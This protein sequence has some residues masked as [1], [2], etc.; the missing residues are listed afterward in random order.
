M[1]HSWTSWHVSHFWTSA[2]NDH[3]DHSCTILENVKVGTLMK[4][5]TF[6]ETWSTLDNSDSL[7]WNWLFIRALMCLLNDLTGSRLP[8]ADS[9]F[10]C[11]EW[12][13]EW[14]W[15][16]QRIGVGLPTR[17]QMI[18]TNTKESNRKTIYKSASSTESGSADL[19][20]FILRILISFSSFFLTELAR[21]LASTSLPQTFLNYSLPFLLLLIQFLTLIPPG[22]LL[23]RGYLMSFL[24]FLESQRIPSP[25]FPVC[26]HI[27]FL[28]EMWRIAD[29]SSTC[30]SSSFLLLS[31]TMKTSACIASE[32]SFIFLFHIPPCLLFHKWKHLFVS[33][34]R[35]EQ[36]R[37]A[38]HVFHQRKHFFHLP[39]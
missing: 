30:S 24:T 15:W 4:K 6:A 16:W 26:V 9:L 8:C 38:G 11:I 31:S 3:L 28:P 35:C 32:S 5:I 37:S 10:L 1:S 17:V 27:S 33:R 29:S 39:V 21:L 25:R 7:S 2:F 22:L 14:W 13:G 34:L 23:F 18:N 36:V 19:A 20:F 12:T